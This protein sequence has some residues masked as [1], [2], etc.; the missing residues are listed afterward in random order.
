MNWNEIEGN[1]EQFKGKVHEKW[2]KL[3]NDDIEVIKGRKEQLVG[4]L[5]ERY[6]FAMDRAEREIH[7]F[8]ASCGCNEDSKS[9]P[10]EKHASNL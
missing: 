7:K 10:N 4:R 9:P 6:G 5:K 8:L 2:G 1:W 3:T